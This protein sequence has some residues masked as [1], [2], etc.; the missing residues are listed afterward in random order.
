MNRLERRSTTM[1]K[2]KGKAAEKGYQT[3]TIGD[4]ANCGMSKED[5]GEGER[6]FEEKTDKGARSGPA[7]PWKVPKRY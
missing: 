2:F 4:D 5:G 6:C 3:S 7:R 1:G